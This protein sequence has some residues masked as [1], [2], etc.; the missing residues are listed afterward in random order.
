MRPLILALALLSGSVVIVA[1]GYFTFIVG[2][3]MTESES[4]L[5]FLNPTGAMDPTLRIG[6][7]FTATSLRGEKGDLLP[8]RRGDVIVHRWPPDTSRIFPKR[9]VGIPGDTV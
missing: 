2:D 4:I 1:A 8:V 9:V 5:T 6:E 7:F 3:A